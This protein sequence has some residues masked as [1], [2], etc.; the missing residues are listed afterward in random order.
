MLIYYWSFLWCFY[1]QRKYVNKSEK[2]SMKQK[3]LGLLTTG[4]DMRRI[5]TNITVLTC[6]HQLIVQS[7]CVMV[8][9][10]TIVSVSRVSILP[11]PTNPRNALS[12]GGNSLSIPLWE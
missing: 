2:S 5:T 3:Q 9:S 12:T 10:K 6:G 11:V 7:P 4:R 8:G 1:D